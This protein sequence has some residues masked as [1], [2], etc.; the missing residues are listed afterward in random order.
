MSGAPEDF[1]DPTFTTEAGV[2]R[3]TKSPT[4]PPLLSLLDSQKSPRTA[5]FFEPTPVREEVV[6]DVLEVARWSGSARCPSVTH[7]KRR[8]RRDSWCEDGR[9]LQTLAKTESIP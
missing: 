6:R 7:P 2:R 3:P 5:R 8:I 1:E 9:K 4:L